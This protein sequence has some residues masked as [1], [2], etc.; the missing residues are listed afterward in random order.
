MSQDTVTVINPF[1]VPSERH[2]EALELW[3]RVAAYMERQAGYVSAG[4][5]RGAQPAGAGLR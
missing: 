5:G 2:D 3:D 1:E 4:M